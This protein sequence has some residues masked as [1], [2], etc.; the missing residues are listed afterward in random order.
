M[1]VFTSRPPEETEGRGLPLLR[2]PA[3]GKINACITS[4]FLLGCYTHYWGGR[5]VPCEKPKCEACEASMP[6]R[7][8]GYVSAILRNSR[9]HVLLEF[10][11]QA[12]DAL[13]AYTTAN[14]QLRGCA[15]ECFRRPATANGRVIVKAIRAELGEMILPDPPDIPK[16]LC[17]MW[18]IVEPD[19]RDSANPEKPDRKRFIIGGEK[20]GEN[21]SAFNPSDH[22][23]QLAR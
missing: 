1:P 7:W 10:T 21:I 3:H 15:I 20:D 22:G 16:M 9:E 19:V 13:D 2:T 14:G 17:K 23:I 8:H 12:C 5:T 4:P 18:N 6:Y 11:A